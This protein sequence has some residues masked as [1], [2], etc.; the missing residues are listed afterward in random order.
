MGMCFE[1]QPPVRLEHC[2]SGRL[3]EHK[4]YQ[5]NSDRNINSWKPVNMK[6]HSYIIHPFIS[7]SRICIFNGI[8]DA[9][10]AHFF[11]THTCQPSTY[12]QQHLLMLHATPVAYFL[13]HIQHYICCTQPCGSSTGTFKLGKNNDWISRN[14]CTLEITP[15]P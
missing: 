5:S 2:K 11:L 7:K 15:L 6:F 12:M 13:T 4:L 8:I 10:A 3:L 9:K 1:K 14:T